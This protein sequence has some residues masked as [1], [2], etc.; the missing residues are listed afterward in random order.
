MQIHKLAAHASSWPPTRALM[1]VCPAAQP[2]H[3]HH[4]QLCHTQASPEALKHPYDRLRT[5]LMPWRGGL[6]KCSG[7]PK[8]QRTTRR[9]HQASQCEQPCPTTR[10]IPRPSNTAPLQC[11]L[12]DSDARRVIPATKHC[13]SFLLFPCA[14]SLVSIKGRGGQSQGLDLREHHSRGLGSDTLSRPVCN[15]YYKRP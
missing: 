4:L 5:R 1:R 3:H 6:V 7:R 2:S 11:V 14:P 13:T 10:R 9:K 8:L 15:P 12:T